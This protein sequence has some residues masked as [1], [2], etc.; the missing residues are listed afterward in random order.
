VIP[1]D[2]LPPVSIKITLPVAS[3]ESAR[4]LNVEVAELT[5]KL[6]NLSPPTVDVASEVKSEEVALLVNVL[7]NV[8]PFALRFVVLAFP[9][10]AVP[11]V[12]E[13]M[14]VAPSAER[15]VVEALVSVAFEM[16]P[17]VKLSAV[18]DTSVVEAWVM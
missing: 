13:L 10:V 14:K 7:P 9:I 4:A 17:F 2:P 15:L 3:S 16:N 11:V 6:V 8:A 18:P 12:L 5:F 1:D